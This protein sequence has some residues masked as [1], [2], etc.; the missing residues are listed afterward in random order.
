V[1]EYDGQYPLRE[2]S[3]SELYALL[4]QHKASLG[5]DVERPALRE[6][7]VRGL[8]I[9]E[10]FKFTYAD[11]RHTCF[12]KVNFVQ[13]EFSG[14]ILERTDFGSS[15]LTNCTFSSCETMRGMVLREARDSKFEFVA[16]SGCNLHERRF[17][18][19]SFRRVGFDDARL[20]CLDFI[21][22]TFDACNFSN[23]QNIAYVDFHGGRLTD[24][25]LQSADFATCQNFVLDGTDV[26]GLRLPVRS[27]DR[28]SQLVRSCTGANMLFNLLFLGAFFSPF[29]LKGVGL[30]ALGHLEVRLM[31]R[32]SLV[33]A[34]LSGT[35]NAAIPSLVQICE[36][37]HCKPVPVWRALLGA[38]TNIWVWAVGIVL[39]VYNAIRAFL[40][41]RIAPM[42]EE[43]QTSGNPPVYFPDL[44]LAAVRLEREGASHLKSIVT[45]IW[46]SYAPF[47]RLHKVI[48]IVFL[49]TILLSLVHFVKF[50]RETVFLPG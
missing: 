1:R 45:E 3:Q 48:S 39:L 30:T 27:S 6:L 38:E 13:C 31:E 16:F 37:I 8:A 19:C 11:L 34:K 25:N 9:P 49:F 43:Q 15:S 33:T 10:G 12:E 50:F 20:E 14:A 18:N 17:E 4:A 2:V 24:C 42:K 21:N 41:W 7:L 47:W 28:W 35:A 44:Q 32:S 46:H 29:I 23:A 22:C 36:I 26:R 5:S 40:T